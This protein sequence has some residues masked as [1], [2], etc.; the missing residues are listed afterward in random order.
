MSDKQLKT[1]EQL[2]KEC[3]EREKIGAAIKGNEQPKCR[4]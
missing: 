2:D 4:H 3:I 1:G